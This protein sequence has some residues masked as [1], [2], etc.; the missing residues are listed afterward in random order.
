MPG[1]FDAACQAIRILKSFGTFIRVGMTV[2]REN[3][4]QVAQVFHLV[5]DL[6]VDAFAVAA[7]TSFGRGADVTGCSEVEHWLN[8]Q[9]ERILEPFASDPLFDAVRRE[10]ETAAREKAINCGA[11]WRSFA[12]NSDGNVRSCL[13]LADS[14]K[15][16]NLDRQNYQD[17]FR[18]PDM[19]L[20]HDAPSPGTDECRGPQRD[21][22]MGCK[23]LST[24]IGCFAKAFRVSE[25]VFPECPWRKKYFPGMSLTVSDGGKL[26]S[27][28]QLL[29][30]T[31][32]A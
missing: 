8:H 29:S 31:V 1:S 15:F 9:L 27:V 26:I 2:T 19:R 18:Q 10:R 7:T 16:G 30:G 23:H 13:F 14:K 32:T 28:E 12:L 24:C 25:T 20:F 11:G 22:T 5:K 4:D 6:G 21:G 3:L 17:V